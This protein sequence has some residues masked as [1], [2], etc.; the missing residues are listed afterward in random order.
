MTTAAYGTRPYQSRNAAVIRFSVGLNQWKL[1]A[2]S[3]PPIM[4]MHHERISCLS[5]RMTATLRN[6]RANPSRHRR[7]NRRDSRHHGKTRPIFMTGSSMLERP[8]ARFRTAPVANR[9]VKKRSGGQRNP[10]GLSLRPI[11]SVCETIARDHPAYLPHADRGTRCLP[12]NLKMQ[13]IL[14]TP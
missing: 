11:F 4:I 3:R 12:T 14:Q 6:P 10:E 7:G 2:F 13:R 9:N 5:R 1:A 8:V